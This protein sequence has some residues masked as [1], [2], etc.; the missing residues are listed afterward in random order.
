MTPL[1]IAVV[2]AGHLG[3]IHTKLLGQVDGVEV[4]AVCDPD[5]AS[6]D[7]VREA[8]EVPTFADYRLVIDSVDAAVIASPTGT[9]AKLADDFLSAGKHVL[10]EKPLTI[11]GDDAH[12]LAMKAAAAGLTLQVGHVERFNPAF[13]ALGDLAVDVK[14]VEAVR[15]SSFPGRCLDVGVVMDLMIHDLD[16]ILSMTAAPLESVRSTGLSVISGH[17]D[18][19]ETRLEFACGL[20]ANVKAS[21]ISPTPARSMQIYGV[22]GYADIDFQSPTLSTVRPCRDIIDRSFNL[23]EE[24]TDPLG[25][26]ATLFADRMKVETNKLEPRNAILDELHDFVISIRTGVSPVV[27]GHAGARAVAVAEQILEAIQHRVWYDQ[28]RSSEIGPHAVAR[29]RIEHASRRRAA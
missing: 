22:N 26:G 14:Y 2:G 6:L 28:P 29:T 23:A 19:A 9:H 18:V 3:R 11:R 20:V 5:E 27:S 1:K 17:E 25:Y 13:T 4:A 12:R 21:R 7:K 16:L 10:A 8:C 15:A 24:V